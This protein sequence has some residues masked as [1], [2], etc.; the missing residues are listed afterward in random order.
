MKIMRALLSL[1]ALFFASA[2][3]AQ[4]PPPIAPEGW[5]ELVEDGMRLYRAPSKASVVFVKTGSMPDK[6]DI[7]FS[8]C[9]R[10]HVC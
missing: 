6:N 5:S 1:V 7:D 8:R 10:R 2:V 3:S 9:S 4:T